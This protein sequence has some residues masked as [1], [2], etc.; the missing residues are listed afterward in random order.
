MIA[1]LNT[2]DKKKRDGK[3]KKLMGWIADKGTDAIIAAMPYVIQVV[4]SWVA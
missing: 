2:N 1:D 4:Q 3:L